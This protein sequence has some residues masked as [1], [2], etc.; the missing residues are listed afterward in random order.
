[1]VNRKKPGHTVLSPYLF[2]AGGL[3]Q[4]HLTVREESNPINGMGKLVS[5]TQPID[6]GH[7][8]FDAQERATFLEAEPKRLAFPAAL[9][10]CPRISTRWGALD[11]GRCKRH[12]NNVER[13]AACA[14]ANGFSA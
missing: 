4:S 11:T 2:D 8:I 5:G 7:Y 6:D 13:I 10:R 9:C 14:R 12:L 3:A 1:M